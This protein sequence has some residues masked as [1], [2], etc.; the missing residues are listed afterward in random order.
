MYVTWKERVR[1]NV[2][3][4][5]VCVC[6]CVCLLSSARSGVETIR[7]VDLTR[8]FGLPKLSLGLIMEDHL[9]VILAVP[10][11]PEGSASHQFFSRTCACFVATKEML[12][13]GCP[14][15][16]PKPAQHQ[17]RHKHKHKHSTSTST[18]HKQKPQQRSQAQS[19]STITSPSHT[20][21]TGQRIFQ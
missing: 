12:R 18:S 19:T 20:L 16:A 14:C 5:F 13:A 21:T 8:N 7:N 2:L 3:R 17:P 6:V 15:P 11:L 10:C 4:T 9:S 1:S